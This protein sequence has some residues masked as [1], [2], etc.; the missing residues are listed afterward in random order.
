MTIAATVPPLMWLLLPPS[1][2]LALVVSSAPAPLA[3]LCVR[4]KSKSHAHVIAEICT[5]SNRM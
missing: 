4:S 3:A 1:V 2:T 5:V